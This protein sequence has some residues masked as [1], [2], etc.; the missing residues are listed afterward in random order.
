MAAKALIQ[1]HTRAI[2]VFDPV[3]QTQTSSSEVEEHL[4]C[5]RASNQ[6]LLTIGNLG[7]AHRDHPDW[8]EKTWLLTK[9]W[10]YVPVCC[11]FLI[12]NLVY[13]KFIHG[14]PRTNQ[15]VIS[16]KYSLQKG[17]LISL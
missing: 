9:K 15:H 6:A 11:S 13:S 10:W 5:L 3:L 12:Q 7:F 16:L 14:V 17:K 8:R 2:G 1:M 4:R